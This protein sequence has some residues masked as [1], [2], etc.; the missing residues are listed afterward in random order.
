MSDIQCTC[1]WNPDRHDDDCPVSL[2]QQLDQKQ[3]D[4]DRALARA[5]ACQREAQIWKQEA[6][7]QSAIVAEIY[8]ELTGKTG[9]PGDWNGARPLKQAILRK[10]AEAVEAFLSDLREK[11]AA[12]ESDYGVTVTRSLV[13]QGQ[14]EQYANRLRQ[15]ADQ[16]ENTHD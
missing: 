8:Q 14:L 5:D 4:L 16:L 11:Q 2:R 6:R 7:T 9:E 12:Q 3:A 10:Q 15:Q 13:G 1:K